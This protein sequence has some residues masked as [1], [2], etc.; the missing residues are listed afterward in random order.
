MSSPNH[1]RISVIVPVRNKA[2]FLRQCLG[3]IVRAAR[4]D[5]RVE[6]IFVD[7]QSIDGS[8]RTLEEFRDSAII[9]SS[10]ADNAAGVR[11]R[12]VMSATGSFLSFLDADCIVPHE[13]FARLRE[14]FHHEWIAA[15]GCTVDLP[16]DGSWVERVWYTLHHRGIGGIRTYLNSGNFAVRAEVFRR[17]GGFDETLETGEDSNLGERLTRDG[18]SIVESPALRVLHVDNPTT[19]TEFFRKEVW[20]AKGMMGSA[21]FGH[22][23]K[24]LAMTILHLGLILAAVG[25][26]IAA[27]LASDARLLAFALAS[28]LLVPLMSVSYRRVLARKGSPVLPSLVLYQTYFLARVVALTGILFKRTGKGHRGE[29]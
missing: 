3:S 8:A 13:Y 14:A 21:G 15:T 11:N 17:L 4:H 18:Y 6:L 5:G 22:I 9:L 1:E 28:F 29:L 23:D 25:W 12:G 27:V 20:H 2:P 26:T 16:I 19:I 24:P 10:A 7:N